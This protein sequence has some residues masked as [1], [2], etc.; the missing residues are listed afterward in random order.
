M[1]SIT[2]NEFTTVRPVYRDLVS[3]L[4]FSYKINLIFNENTDL[5]IVIDN[6]WASI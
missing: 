2:I 6:L 5:N 4:I 3:Q 1:H